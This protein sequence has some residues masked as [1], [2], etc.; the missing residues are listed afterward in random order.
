V[1][2]QVLVPWAGDP[3][4]YVRASVGY[5]LAYLAEEETYQV[6]VKQLMTDWVNTPPG[7]ERGETWRYRWAAASACK[8]I[9]II[10]SEW[11]KDLAYQGLTDLARFNDIRIADSVIHSLVFLSLQGQ[12]I[13]TLSVLKKWVDEN[14]VNDKDNEAAETRLNVLF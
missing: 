7:R 13:T 1:R 4:A 12:L 14:G 10:E 3:R 9:G 6:Q 5:A 8:Q 11:A 2:E